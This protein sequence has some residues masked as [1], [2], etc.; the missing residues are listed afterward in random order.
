[1]NSRGSER[2]RHQ[3]TRNANV[4]RNVVACSGSSTPDATGAIPLYS[5][6]KLILARETAAINRDG[7]SDP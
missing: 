6:G 5:L 4:L 3:G 7:G 2:T 1:M